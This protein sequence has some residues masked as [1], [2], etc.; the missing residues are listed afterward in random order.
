LCLFAMV[1]SSEG[2]LRPEVAFIGDA[3]MIKAS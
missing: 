1:A 3:S 2:V